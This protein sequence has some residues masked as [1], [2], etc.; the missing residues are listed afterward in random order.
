ML[1][2]VG[3]VG[4]VFRAMHVWIAGANRPC[5]VLHVHV[6]APGSRWGVGRVGYIRGA[7]SVVHLSGLVCLQGCTVWARWSLAAGGPA[8]CGVL[9]HRRRAMGLKGGGTVHAC[10][11][12]LWGWSLG[13]GL[14]WGL[15]LGLN[16]GLGWGWG[17][18]LSLAGRRA[19]NRAN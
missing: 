15:G 8:C 5:I 13:L 12:P 7:V 14:N 10:T 1:R 18:F 4:L 9:G 19:D 11:V 2:G 3:K 16:W 6:V 17:V